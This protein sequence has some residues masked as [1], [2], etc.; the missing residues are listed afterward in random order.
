MR[1]L[2]VNQVDLKFKLCPC[3]VRRGQTRRGGHRMTEAETGGMWSRASE[4][5]Q[6]LEAGRGG[7]PFLEPSE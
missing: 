5:L 7:G 3:K 4:H 6:S 2:W 1:S